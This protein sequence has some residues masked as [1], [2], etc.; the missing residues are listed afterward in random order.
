MARS[1]VKRFSVLRPT[2]PRFQCFLGP[3]NATWPV[4]SPVDYSTGLFHRAVF[5][6]FCLIR[7]LKRLC[8]ALLALGI[9]LLAGYVFRAPI[10]RTSADL[11]IVNQSVTNADAIVVL[12]GGLQTRPF[13]AAKLY[14]EGLAP[15]ILLMNVR[16]DPTTELGITSTEQELTRKVLLAQGVAETNLVAI[17]NRVA[18]SHDE[19]MAVRDWAKQSGAK[20]LLIPTDLFH[21]RRARWLFEKEL[22][23]M[24][25]AV[26]VTAVPTGQYTAAN[27]WQNEEG[28]VSFQNEVIKYAFY[29]L[30]Y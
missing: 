8:L 27:W 30:K 7:F 25:V 18:S 12:G 6:H 26:I 17:G 11:W 23:G 28:L 14:H 21:T 4:K 20:R 5:Q 2:G 22:G 29:R 15:R 16:S 3:W 19:A 24:S 13:A 9:L 1:A 10:L